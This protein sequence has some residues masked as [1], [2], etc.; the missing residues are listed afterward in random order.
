MKRFITARV[1]RG[2]AVA[3]AAAGVAAA[4]PVAASAYQGYGATL[5]PYTAA[6]VQQ[7]ASSRVR[8]EGTATRKGAWFTLRYS[9]QYPGISY[10]GQYPGTGEI[11]LAS[12][13]TTASAW[14][15][16]SRP[17]LGNWRGAGYYQVCAF[18]AQG[19]NTL[20]N[21]RIFVDDDPV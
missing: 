7:Y 8:G 17:E 13:V 4:A 10:T 1:S 9:G 3:L 11:V 16:E 5:T 12:P 21:F 6:C 18:D 20:V 15:A 2:L 19:T 14:A